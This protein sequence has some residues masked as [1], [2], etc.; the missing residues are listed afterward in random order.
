MSKIVVS[1]MTEI[2]YYSARMTHPERLSAVDCGPPLS[3]Y[4]PT[5]REVADAESIYQFTQSSRNCHHTRTVFFSNVTKWL[6]AH[7]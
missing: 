7:S 1:N 4:L 3:T 6:Y 2:T 5:Y